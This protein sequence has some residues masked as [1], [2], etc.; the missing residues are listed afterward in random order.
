MKKKTP[1]SCR[2]YT[3]MSSLRMYK[4]KDICVLELGTSSSRPENQKI[5]S[6]MEKEGNY[7]ECHGKV[8]GYLSNGR[9]VMSSQTGLY[10]FS[11]AEEQKPWGWLV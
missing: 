6:L 7:K 3:D 8:K 9:S 11:R 5:G 10:W 2:G 4:D 1:A